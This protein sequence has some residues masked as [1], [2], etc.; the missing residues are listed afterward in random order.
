MR[1]TECKSWA[2][3]NVTEKLGK[4]SLNK[5][6]QMGPWVS[7]EHK[8]STRKIAKWPLTYIPPTHNF[9]P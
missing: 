3:E 4:K 2:S 9:D 7:L 8:K 5:S 1:V 6:G